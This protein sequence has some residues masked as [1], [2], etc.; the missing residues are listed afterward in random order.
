MDI[1]CEFRFL[2]TSRHDDGR[3]VFINQGGVGKIC[4]I[5]RSINERRNCSRPCDLDLLADGCG[6]TDRARWRIR[7]EA[8]HSKQHGGATQGAGGQNA[9]SEITRFRGSFRFHDGFF[10]IFEVK[11][12]VLNRMSSDFGRLCRRKSDKRDCVP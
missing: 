1:E 2:R 5:A 4:A 12:C 10:P 3:H 7:R 8:E 9:R 6:H 11:S